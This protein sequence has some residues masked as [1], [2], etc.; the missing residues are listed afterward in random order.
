M[1]IVIRDFKNVK[2]GD[3]FNFYPMGDWHW[4]TTACARDI[5]SHDVDVIRHDSRAIWLG[6]G[7]YADQIV[8]GDRRFDP[9]VIDPEFWNGS[10][11]DIAGAHELARQALLDTVRPIMPKCLGLLEGNHEST[12]IKM[13]H[14]SLVTA[15]VEDYRRRA[16]KRGLKVNEWATGL[17]YTSVLILRFFPVQVTNG[18]KAHYGH[19]ELIIYAT[20]GAGAA[21]TL[22]GRTGRLAAAFA[23]LPEADLYLAGHVHDKLLHAVDTLALAY[24]N[25]NAPPVP[26]ATRKWLVLVPSFYRTH[27]NGVSTYGDARGYAPSVLGCYKFTIWPFGQRVRKHSGGHK[28]KERA[29]QEYDYN[30]PVVTTTEMLEGSGIRGGL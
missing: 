11:Q 14:G 18:K 16:R 12:A 20:H 29:W 1:L 10:G 17:T 28:G 2:R 24:G 5:L 3:Y 15:M 13:G 22:S 7:D 25:K 8:M 23:W 19:T 4:G 26:I 30:R 6:T 27:V 21:Q 9:R